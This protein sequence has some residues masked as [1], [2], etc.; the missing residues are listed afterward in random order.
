MNNNFDINIID[1]FKKFADSQN[2]YIEAAISY[3]VSILK[4][5]SDK[6]CKLLAEILELENSIGEWIVS[7]EKKLMSTKLFQPTS[8]EI[9]EIVN[10]AISSYNETNKKNIKELNKQ[11][12][13]ELNKKIDGSNKQNNKELNLY[14]TQIIQMLKDLTN[15]V[16][17]LES[18]SQK[19][20][21]A[22]VATQTFVNGLCSSNKKVYVENILKK[23]LES[24]DN[25]LSNNNKKL[26]NE[27]IINE[28]ENNETP[29]HTSEVND[30]IL[31]DITSEK[32]QQSTTKRQ[33]VI[34][35]SSIDKTRVAN[36]ENKNIDN[37]KV[38]ES[39][40]KL[41]LKT[42]MKTSRKTTITK[43]K[44][45]VGNDYTKEQFKNNKEIGIGCKH[46]AFL[47]FDGGMTSLSKDIFEKDVKLE[48]DTYYFEREG[49]K[50]LVFRNIDSANADVPNDS[51]TLMKL[52]EGCQKIDNNIVVDILNK[53]RIDGIDGENSILIG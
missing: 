27:N 21:M 29:S 39:C 38:N 22:D 15:K 12:I 10:K 40:E 42:I 26:G 3:F 47:R 23:D 33:V 19:K 49:K 5:N 35:G 24:E 53:A 25:V 4:H 50:Y 18:I 13:E 11:S 52:P 6:E 36:E 37:P 30:T 31:E 1:Y 9:A 2:K 43:Y 51:F 20:E 14:H 41:Y 28:E 7:Y 17:R 48:K 45:K 8:Q 44:E 34:D 46:R 16:D 32:N